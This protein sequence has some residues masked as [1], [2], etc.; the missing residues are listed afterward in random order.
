MGAPL[1]NE[2]IVRELEHLQDQIVTTT[3]LVNHTPNMTKKQLEST[4]ALKENKEIIVK[5][6]DKGSATVVMSLDSYVQEA[7]RQLSNS[8]H[9]TPLAEYIAPIATSKISSVLHRIKRMGYISA[10]QLCYLDPPPETPRNRQ[11]HLLP[12]IHKTRDKCP[13]NNKMPPGRPIVSDC[14][15]ES[16]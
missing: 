11:L 9:Y 5:P 2:D 10:K 16:Y 15:C 8:K 12:K 7:E 3:R 1:K 4:R 14:G 13:Q 6:A